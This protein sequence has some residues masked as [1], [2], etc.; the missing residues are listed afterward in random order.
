MPK[1]V[2]VQE[3]RNENLAS[4]HAADT[5]PP[6]MGDLKR[7]V[8]RGGFAKVCSQG[9]TIVLRIGSVIVLARLLDPKDFGLVGMVTVVTGA[10]G[11]FKDAG[12]S[13]V[14][15][16]RPQITHDELSALFWINMLVGGVLALLTVSL[17]PLLTAFYREPRLIAI[18]V[19][20]AAGFIVNAAGVQHAALLNRQMRFTTISVIEILSWIASVS[21]GVGMALSGFGYWA[22]V[23]M[24]ITSPAVWTVGAWLTTAWIPGPPRR[25]TGVYSMVRFGGTVTLNMIVVYIAYNADKLLIG[26]I[27]GAEALGL[28]GRAYQLIS[29]PTE[30][31]NGAVG[32]IA[33]SALA[34]VQEEPARFKSYFLKSYALVLTC[35][36]PVT[37]ACA[38]LADDIVVVLLGAKWNAAAP[39]F[40]LMAPTILTF[41]LINPLG[42][43]LFGSG[44][45]GRS[46]KM[47][48]V[49]APTVILGY[50]SGLPY[51]PSGVAFGYSAMMTLLCLPLMRWA[52]SGSVISFADLMLVIR[53]PFMSAAVAALL[54]FGV[55]RADRR[56]GLASVQAGRRCQCRRHILCADAVVRHWS[57][58]ILS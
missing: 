31:L 13:M 49:I 55:E 17:A 30:N 51:G 12:L 52:T 5:Q 36:L 45:V 34:R 8:L 50:A 39:I 6:V 11:L 1:T 54:A 48:F 14:T 35:T 57:E 44:R 22:L 53:P 9:A 41:A 42:W 15:I 3:I 46:L 10:F 43:M 26:R 40:R 24:T 21:V 33:V 37:V 38:L 32:G 25:V 27:W 20:L 23:G 47:A 56:F 19:P 58:I 7:K 2:S 28:Y 4:V 18:A 29:I 16:Q